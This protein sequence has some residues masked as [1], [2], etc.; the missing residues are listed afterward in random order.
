MIEKKILI[1]ELF[2]KVDD[3]LVMRFFDTNSHK[4]LDEKI[5]VLTALKNGAVPFEIPKYYD[6]LELMP[7]DDTLWD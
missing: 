5:E 1:N 4:L 7:N 2:I 6:I 3:Y